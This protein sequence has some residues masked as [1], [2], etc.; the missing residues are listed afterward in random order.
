MDTEIQNLNVAIELILS[1]C[2]ILQD[3]ALSEYSSN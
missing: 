3:L 2:I 1:K